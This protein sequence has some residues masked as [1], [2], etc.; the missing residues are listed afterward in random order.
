M[1]RRP[2]RSTLFPYT[3][4]FRSRA[5]CTYCTFRKDPDDPDAWTMTPDEIATWSARGRTLG[6]KE[7]LMCLGDKPEV[8]FPAYRATLAGLG[9]RPTAAYV[10][11]ACAIA[12]QCGLLTHTN[13][14]LLSPAVL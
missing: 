12:L 14:G 5:R 9:H 3:T 1:I 4:L 2:P 6:C 11:H 10:Q 8:A 13:D 7:A